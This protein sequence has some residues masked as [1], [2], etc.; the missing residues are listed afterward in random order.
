LIKHNFSTLFKQTD[1]SEVFGFIGDNYQR[2]RIKIISITKD[3]PLADTYNVYG[4]S[5][6]KDNIVEFRGTLEIV[7]IRKLLITQHGCEDEDKYKGF[8]GEFVILGNYKLLENK[9]QKYPGVFQ[10][11]F[12]SDFFLDKNN[13]V[14]YDDIEN[15]S[16]GYTNNQFVGQWTSYKNNLVKRCN[17]GDYRIPNSGD[18]DI[19]AAEFSP[20]D[21]YLKN[22]WQSIRDLMTNQNNEKAKQV[23][24]A[25]WWAE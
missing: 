24:E 10:G 16:D 2:L 12:R 7:H 23:E 17:W 20:D 11:S 3:A 15:C 14:I 18:F 4:K 8:K 9:N 13:K 6:I 1:N 22:G 5:Q 21:K 25:K 19:G